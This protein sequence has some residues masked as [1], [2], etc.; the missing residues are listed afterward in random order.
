MVNVYILTEEGCEYTKEGC[1]HVTNL[2]KENFNETNELTFSMGYA[3][4]KP[5]YMIKELELHPNSYLAISTDHNIITVNPDGIPVFK[6]AL[7]DLPNQSSWE[8][9]CMVFDKH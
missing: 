8:T 9:A 4:N 5:N 7:T 6:E 1:M 3:Y 2:L